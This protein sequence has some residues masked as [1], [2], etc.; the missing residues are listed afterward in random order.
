MHESAD[1]MDKT[2]PVNMS[3]LLSVDRVGPYR[4]SGSHFHE[5][6]EIG[7]YLSG[8]GVAVVGDTHIPFTRGTVVCYPPDI[9]HSER[10]KDACLGYFIATD[11]FRFVEKTIPVCTDHFG[12]K[13][14]RIVSLLHHEWSQKL[15]RWEEASDHLFQLLLIHLERQCSP[16]PTTHPLVSTLCSEVER[17]VADPEFHVGD[18]LS[19]LPMSSDHLRRLFIREVGCSPLVYLNELRV[20]KAKQLLHEG[21]WRVK[22]VAMQVG[23]QDEYYFSRL[24]LKQTGYR[25]QAYSRSVQV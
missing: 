9:P 18:A 13:F 24:F 7:F 25:P 6:W 11:R 4:G 19:R 5:Y 23:I 10:S 20:T 8:Q 1:L 12:S 17:H 2:A 15:L 16:S 21:R 22:E 3:K 14:F